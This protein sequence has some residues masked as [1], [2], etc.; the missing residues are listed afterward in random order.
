MREL[1]SSTS[2]RTLSINQRAL[3]VNGYARLVNK[4]I[5]TLM[6]SRWLSLTT[7][8]R[9]WMRMVRR[10]LASTSWKTRLLLWASLTLVNKLS[11]W[12][13]KSTMMET[14]SL[15]NSSSL[16]KVARKQRR[17]YK[18]TAMM[19]KT[20]TLTSSSISS[21]DWQLVTCN[22]QRI[23]R[24]ASASTTVRKDVKRSLMPSSVARATRCPKKVKEWFT[25]TKS[26]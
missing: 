9:S 14:S 4:S 3:C 15:K 6:S 20:L 16:S 24:S 25:T 22:P 21:R 23:W 10:Q 18:S 19:M 26:K 11:R 8:S 13:M 2:P 5:L 17:P 7:A 12:C 1:A